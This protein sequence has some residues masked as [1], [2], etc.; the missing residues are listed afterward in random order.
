VSG[1]EIGSLR[2]SR[3][4]PKGSSINNEDN[5]DGD[6]GGGDYANGNVEFQELFDCPSQKVPGIL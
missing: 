3:I 2:A 1:R 6:N 5:A 4:F